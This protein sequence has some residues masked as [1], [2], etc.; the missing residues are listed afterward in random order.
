M[1][2][3]NHNREGGKMQIKQKTDLFQIKTL[4]T[5]V[6]DIDEGSRLVKDYWSKFGIID[7][8][9]DMIVRGAFAKSITERGATSTSNRKIKALR[10]HDWDHEIGVVKELEEDESGLLATVQLG[11]ST[12]GNDALLDYQDGIIT[13]HSIGFRYVANGM[14]R[15]EDTEKPYWVISEV[16]LWEG[17]AV[18]FG[19]NSECNVVDVAKGETKQSILSKLN[20]EMF[21]LTKALRNPQ[22]TD[23]SL[24]NIEIG[25]NML[26]KRYNDLLNM[27]II[28]LITKT[29]KNV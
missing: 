9:D 24:Y 16:E 7:S 15:V 10:Y 21:A 11:R 4:S 13:E 23:E 14:K 8:D 6:L 2:Q 27:N 3:Q 12:K 18:A 25:L 26:Q 20:A 17:S 1:N 28:D 22:R 29:E 5:K 19:A